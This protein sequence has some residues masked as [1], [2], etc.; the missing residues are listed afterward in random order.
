MEQYMSFNGVNR[1]PSVAK[2]RICQKLMSDCRWH[3]PPDLSVQLRQSAQR[4]DQTGQWPATDLIA[5]EE[6]GALRWAVPRSFGGEEL[7]PLALH[8]RYES[9]AAASLPTALILTQ[10]DS[11][12]GML[13]MTDND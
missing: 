10:R 8:L 9:L 4:H 7:A 6:S 5:L 1:C 11:A 12:I 2:E 3:L 13:A